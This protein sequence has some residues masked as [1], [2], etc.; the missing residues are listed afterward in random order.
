MKTP[1]YKFNVIKQMK[2]SQVKELQKD[3]Q[4][5]EFMKKVQNSLSQGLLKANYKKRQNKIKQE[6]FGR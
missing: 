2:P 4:Y 6:I 3:R 5:K 1:E